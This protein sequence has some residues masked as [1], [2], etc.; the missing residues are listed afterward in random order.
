MTVTTGAP[1][2]WHR[3]AADPSG[4]TTRRIANAAETKA[5]AATAS[6][7]RTPVPDMSPAE[8]A[9]PLRTVAAAEEAQRTAAK[10]I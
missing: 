5:A 2:R 7:D 6:T 10:A 8:F 4:W 1:E 9:R 3:S